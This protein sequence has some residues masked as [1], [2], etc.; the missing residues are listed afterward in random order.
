MK[1]NKMD[2]D[3][4]VNITQDFGIDQTQIGI[5]LQELWEYNLTYGLD[6]RN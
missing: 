3:C 1:E 4:S 6:E 5:D 2:S